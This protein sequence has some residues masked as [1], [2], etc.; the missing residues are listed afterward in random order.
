[1]A[2]GLCQKQ[3]PTEVTNQTLLLHV[4]AELQK[5]FI[6]QHLHFQI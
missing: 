6:I 5:F 4:I 2:V 1:M 3:R